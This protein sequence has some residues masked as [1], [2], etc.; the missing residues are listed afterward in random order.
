MDENSRKRRTALKKLV[1]ALTGSGLAIFV[2]LH[3]VGNL[4][5]FISGEALNSYGAFFDNLAGGIVLRGMEACLALFI[6]AHAWFA[7]QDRLENRRYAVK[8]AMRRTS[9]KASV[10]V[11][12]AKCMLCTGIY[13]GIFICIHFYLFRIYD[14]QLPL[15]DKLSYFMKDP[16]LFCLHLGAAACAAVHV[17][18]G[19]WSALQNLGFDIDKYGK[20][21]RIVSY[22]IGGAAGLVFAAAAIF[23]HFA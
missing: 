13:L 2:L 22:A 16:L 8:Y 9:D 7:L 20:A 14:C 4:T 21:S 19:I 5:V 3:T 10:N 11:F 18:S 1:L 17:G 23:M 6:G 12:S 15:Y